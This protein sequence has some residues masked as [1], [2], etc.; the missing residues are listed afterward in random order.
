MISHHQRVQPQQEP[1]DAAAA[2]QEYKS[3]L[4]EVQQLL[5]DDPHDAQCLA[6]RDELL[7]SISA[8]QG[9]LPAGLVAHDV[10]ASAGPAA[11]GPAAGAAPHAGA[12]EAESFIGPA[13]PAHISAAPDSPGLAGAA[14]ASSA[15]APVSA[16]APADSGGGGSADEQQQ[17]AAKRRRLTAP[18]SGN[19]RMHPGNCYAE[20]EP[21]FAALA[22]RHSGLAR[23]VRLRRDGRWKCPCC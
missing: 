23:H 4:T 19:A 11:T 6:I 16:T 21:D 13:M 5:R 18:G 14:P 20:E 12:A 17:L 3:S 9:V 7:Q 10:P 1:A 8:L 2:L 15:A 22:A